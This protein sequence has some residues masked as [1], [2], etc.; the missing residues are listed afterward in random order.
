MP[1]TS[2]LKCLS[3]EPTWPWTRTLEPFLSWW[4]PSECPVK[5]IASCLATCVL[6][7]QSS[8]F[9]TRLTPY[10][11]PLNRLPLAK[12]PPI[13][14]V[15]SYPWCLSVAVWTGT[16]LPALVL[17]PRTNLLTLEQPEV[18]EHLLE[19]KAMVH[20]ETQIQR[21]QRGCRSFH[22]FFAPS[23]R[24]EIEEWLLESCPTKQ[25]AKGGFTEES[26]HGYA[27]STTIKIHDLRN[28]ILSR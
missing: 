11:I 27:Q 2:L 23:W 25:V 21:R 24:C 13:K 1:I 17:H 4:C 18:L 7:D 14:I 12:F 20:S 9:Q 5:Y 22:S 8:V 28:Y 26:Q 19:E 10:K 16:F 3:E 15:T 6:K